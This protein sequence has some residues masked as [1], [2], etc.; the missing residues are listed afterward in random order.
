MKKTKLLA[1][2]ALI[3]PAMAHGQGFYA[4]L[5][6]GEARSDAKIA[7]HVL[8]RHHRPLRAAAAPAF[9]CAAVSR[10][11]RFFALEAAYVDFGEIESHFD[12]DDC[13][14]GAPGPVRS[15]CA[16]P[17]VESS[18]RWWA[19]CRSANTGISMRAWAGAR[20]TS[21]AMRSVGLASKP[22]NENTAFNYGIGAGY[23]FNEHWG[24]AARLQRVQ[25]GGLLEHTLDGD[26]GVYNLGETSVTSLGVSYRW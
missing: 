14:S 24:V 26:F 3:V 11:G 4:G 19:F 21:N 23:R 7:K 20:S 25:P 2:L 18:S 16:L 5:D 9:G 8:R 1:A 12:P 22:K 17:A 13:P 15:T 10:F 6:V